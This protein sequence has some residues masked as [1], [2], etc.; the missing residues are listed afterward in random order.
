MEL[1]W[2]EDFVT[3]AEASSFSRAAQARHVTQSAFSRRIKQLEAWVGTPLISR[4]TIPAELTREGRAFLPFAQETIRNFNAT[5]DSL[6]G[7][8]KNAHKQLTFAAL[9]TLTVT[10]LP[11][12]IRQ[13][14]AVE[15]QLH[16]RIIPDR[17]GIED[18]LDALVSAEADFFLTYHH[19]FV[20]I[21]LDPEQ[22][23][24]LTLAHEVILP[25]VSPGLAD[26]LLARPGL[27]RDEAK[28]TGQP[29]VI[30]VIG[31]LG[32]HNLALPYL[33]YGRSSFIGTALEV[34]FAAHPIARVV[35]HQNSISA[36]L[37]EMALR[38]FG[39]CWLPHNL[40][41]EDLAAGR[42]VR[43]SGD[44]DLEL[45]AEIRLY[46]YLGDG[47]SLRPAFW[48]KIVGVLAPQG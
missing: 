27:S 16:T 10:Q 42:L 39:M 29:D 13:I 6:G 25:V 45:R 23:D 24:S 9:H 3:L 15:P 32:R 22:F 1:K 31:V 47:R 4:A 33:D 34:L 17:G 12:W 40:I 37:R 38:D 36:G 44:A 43:A 26:D 5:R 46:R 35:V 11:E 48:N 30:D 41:A 7:G 14:K 20:P 2:L 19:S 28:V 21:M 18:N 8:R